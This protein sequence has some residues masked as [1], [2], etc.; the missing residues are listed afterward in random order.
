MAPKQPPDQPQG[1]NQP[2][3]APVLPAVD[4]QLLQQLMA[5]N[6]QMLQL[7]MQQQQN[8]Q[9]P[10][11]PQAGGGGGN[12]QVTATASMKPVPPEEFTGAGY[13]AWKKRLEDWQALFAN[14]DAAQ[15]APL[16]KRALKGDAAAIARAAVP[17]D[18]LQ[19][20]DAFDRICA[21]S[22]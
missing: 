14:L 19:Q 16:L 8:A 5:Q 6:A 1:D 21:R 20:P 11:Q 22:I 13:E 17:G 12:V 9:P 18:Q 2:A 10:L 4:P 7:M 15:K 3:A